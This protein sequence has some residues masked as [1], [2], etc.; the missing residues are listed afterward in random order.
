[1]SITEILDYAKKTGTERDQRVQQLIKLQEQLEQIY[2]HSYLPGAEERI[3]RVLA[4]KRQLEND[5]FFPGL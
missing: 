5:L 1:M 4:A 2:Q 3:N